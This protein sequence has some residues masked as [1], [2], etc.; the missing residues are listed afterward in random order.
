M[1]FVT[2]NRHYG[3]SSPTVLSPTLLLHPKTKHWIHCPWL[4]PYTRIMS[5]VL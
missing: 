2:R 1:E 4:S 3:V 5:G